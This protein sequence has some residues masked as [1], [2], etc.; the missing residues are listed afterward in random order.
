MQQLVTQLTRAR[1]AKKM[2]LTDIADLTLINVQ[3]LQNMEQGNFTFLP[4]AYVR[5][6]LREYASAVGLNPDEIMSTY[7]ALAKEPTDPA[8]PE[9]VET[10]APAP[11]QSVPATQQQEIAVQHESEPPPTHPVSA[12][13]RAQKAITPTTIRIVL[14][15]VIVLVA[16]IVVWNLLTPSRNGAVKEIAF[17]SVMKEHEGRDQQAETTAT[18]EEPDSLTLQAVTTDS[19]WVLIVA[20][21]GEPIERLMRAGT[22]ATWKAAGKFTISVGNA[23][24]LE[25]TLNDKP[26]GPLGRAGAVVRNRVITAG[27][28]SGH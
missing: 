17:D 10:P 2:S 5:A 11:L 22:R 13:D 8:R 6:F 26:L 21:G 23:G 27:E 20:D 25:F 9:A 14:T 7:I 4:Q 28:L 3:F 12:T 1:E 15:G 18:T 19:V 24:A 16:A